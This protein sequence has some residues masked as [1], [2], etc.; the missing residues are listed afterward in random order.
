[1]SSV[2]VAL[3]SGAESLQDS[4]DL[5]ANRIY[6]QCNNS[7]NHGGFKPAQRAEF[8]VACLRSVA[9][10]IESDAADELKPAPETVVEN[11]PA[12]DPNAGAQGDQPGGD[13][14]PSGEGGTGAASGEAPAGEQ[15]AAE[16]PTPTPGVPPTPPPVG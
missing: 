10:Q 7:T 1:M 3:P 4:A 11:P 12:V 14:A 15:P 13:G 6:N 9:M 2:K 16:T 5:L 8:L